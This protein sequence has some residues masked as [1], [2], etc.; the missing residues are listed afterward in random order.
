MTEQPEDMFVDIMNEKAQAFDRLCAERHEA[1]A[2]EYGAFTF[3]ENDV[4]RMML[5][6]L[7]DTANYCRMQ[8]VKL[9]L[10]QE[11]LEVEVAEQFG[12]GEDVEN[13][14]IGVKAFKGVGEVGWGKK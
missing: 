7:A 14:Q 1:G 9:M 3:L 4:V 12:S 5:E 8:A 11:A 10:L 2:V 13:I 6:E